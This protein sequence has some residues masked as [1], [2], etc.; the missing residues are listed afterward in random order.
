MKKEYQQRRQGFMGVAEVAGKELFAPGFCGYREK[1]RAWG[2]GL[3]RQ[4]QGPSEQ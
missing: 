2:T 1:E 3:E 4:N